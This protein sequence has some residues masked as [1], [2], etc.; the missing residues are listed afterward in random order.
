MSGPY[1]LVD[2]LLTELEAHEVHITSG[3]GREAVKALSIYGKVVGHP[4]QL[5]MGDALAYACAKAYHIPL[6]YKGEDFRKTDL[7]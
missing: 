2:E 7:A 4:A 3:M 1:P 5:N 6:L